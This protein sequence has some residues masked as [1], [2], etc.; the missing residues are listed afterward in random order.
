ML[1]E[2]LLKNQLFMSLISLIFL[3]ILIKAL[4]TKKR[5]DK[6]SYRIE[7]RVSIIQPNHTE[8]SIF[9]Y[10]KLD[11]I[12]KSEFKSK[13]LM[14]K[15][16]Y[17]LYTQLV[18]LLENTDAKQ[19]YRLFSQV[20]MGEFI[21]TPDNLAFRLINGKRVDF[22]IIDMSGHPVIVIEY[23]GGGHYQND[24]IER[25][26]IKKEACRKANIEYVEFPKQYDKLH[27][28]RISQILNNRFSKK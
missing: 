19:K 22:L 14:N 24:A 20:A 23:Q 17:K 2:Q 16:E 11:T 9:S 3:V 18:A 25:D 1:F 5:K 4:F 8:N 15:S 7:P 12:A 26:A 6:I 10:S 28:Q 13:P 21:Q 27:F